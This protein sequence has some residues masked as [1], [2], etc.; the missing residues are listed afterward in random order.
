MYITTV[1]KCSVNTSTYLQFSPQQTSPEY[2]DN[3]GLS[4]HTNTPSCLKLL[5]PPSY[6]QFF[7]RRM[8]L[9]FVRKFRGPLTTA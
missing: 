3:L 7:C 5:H 6:K 2:L 1:L 4:R 9:N 8:L